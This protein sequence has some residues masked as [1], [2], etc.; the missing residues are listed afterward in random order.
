MPYSRIDHSRAGLQTAG[1]AALLPGDPVGWLA[2]DGR[3]LW[4]EESGGQQEGFEHRI[5]FGSQML[6]A[7]RAEFP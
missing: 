3:R 1:I 7:R 2:R 4:G 5:S 6:L